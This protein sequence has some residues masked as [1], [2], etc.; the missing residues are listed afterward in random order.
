MKPKIFP[1]LLAPFSF[2]GERRPYL[3]LHLLFWANDECAQPHLEVGY[4]NSTVE[5][6]SDMPPI[7]N[8]SED[9]AQLLPR[10]AAPSGR[11]S[12]LPVALEDVGANVEVPCRKSVGTG[13]PQLA[14][15]STT[16]NEG[17]EEAEPEKARSELCCCRA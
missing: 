4:S 1:L 5:E 14:E 17:M 11:Y 3:L 9:V 15:T 13:P 12:Y 8:L 16:Q 6:V 7:H 10:R 2:W